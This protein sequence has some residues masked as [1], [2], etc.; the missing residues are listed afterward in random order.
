SIHKGSATTCF[1]VAGPRLASAAEFEHEP[2]K[3]RVAGMK[4]ARVA[5]KEMGRP[6][7]IFDRQKA[8]ELRR[9]GPRPALIDYQR[10]SRLGGVPTPLAE[11]RGRLAV[12]TPML[13]QNQPQPLEAAGAGIGCID[14][15]R[16]A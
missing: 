14:P 12:E 11:D 3:E 10:P 6:R 2:I 7:R 15:G 5:G 16:S 1:S 13:L 4:Q 8:V 9:Q